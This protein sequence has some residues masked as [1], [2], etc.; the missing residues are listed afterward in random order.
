[1]TRSGW[2]GGNRTPADDATR[3]RPAGRT[4]ESQEEAD[5]AAPGRR[6]DG[7]NRAPRP[8]ASGE[9]TEEG[10][11]GSGARATPTG[12]QPQAGR[13]A[14]DQ[15]DGDAETRYLSRLWPHVGQRVLG[16]ATPDQGEPR[17]RT[18]MDDGSGIVAC[19]PATREG[20]SRVAAPAFP[21][22]RVSA[23]GHQRAR[24]AGGPRAQ[25]LL[26]QHDRRCH[27]PYPCALHD[28][29]A[30]NMRLLGS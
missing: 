19:H 21:V 8:A 23:V 2:G 13:K 11:F 3:P 15:G 27:Q 1:M 25:T 17:D 14:Q 10:R 16:P 18:G 5:H 7:A 24:V 20:G 30:E 28:S 22:G 6:G 26:D 9:V 4:E 29:T 12:F